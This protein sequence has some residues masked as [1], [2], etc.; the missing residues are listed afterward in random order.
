MNR[1]TYFCD[2]QT[3]GQ[4]GEKRMSHTKV[5]RNKY[6]RSMYQI[7]PDTQNVPEYF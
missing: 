7:H 3:G 1:R 4:K 2:R 6:L 5:G